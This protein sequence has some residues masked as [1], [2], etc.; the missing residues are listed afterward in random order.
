MNV[1]DFVWANRE[2][3]FLL[4]LAGA[5]VLAMWLGTVAEIN[6]ANGEKAPGLV[7]STAMSALWPVACVAAFAYSA[8][9]VYR[10]VRR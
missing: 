4:W 10:K 2:P 8:A 7:W 1:F 3:L 5:V 9:A 6:E